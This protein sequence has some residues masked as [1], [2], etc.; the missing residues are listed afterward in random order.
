MRNGFITIWLMTTLTLMMGC[1]SMPEPS[2]ENKETPETEL[3]NHCNK[4]SAVDDDY[5]WSIP[6]YHGILT[7]QPP[8]FG[9]TQTRGEPDQFI[10]CSDCPCPT[11]KNATE[12]RQLKDKTASKSNP[13]KVVIRFEH[14]SYLL[15]ERQRQ[16][17]TRLF[18]SL[19][20][21]YQLTV[22]GYTDDTS[23]GGTI[24]NES[25]AQFRAESVLDITSPSTNR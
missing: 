23:P 5:P 6:G 8:S 4:I 12:H 15:N 13:S 22:T 16:I 20:G 21:Q 10:V 17:L 1:A 2:S 11:P 7:K 3:V 18:Q 24:T 9:I 25:L 14:A 19:P